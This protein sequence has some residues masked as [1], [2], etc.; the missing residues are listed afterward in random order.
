MSEDLVAGYYAA[1]RIGGEAEE[2]MMDL[3]A[4]DAVYDEPFSGLDEPAVGREGIR[5][6][7]RA[8][9]SSPLPDMELDVLSVTIDGASACCTWEC[10]SPAFPAPVRG[11]DRYEFRDGLISRLEVRIDDPA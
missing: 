6:R 8:G 4:D 5:D 7:L 9:W 2:Q 1:M 11:T 10:R 3:F